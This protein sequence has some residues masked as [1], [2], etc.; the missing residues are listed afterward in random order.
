MKN[1]K[2]LFMLFLGVLSLSVN[3]QY[4]YNVVIG[5]PKIVLLDLEV[6]NDTSITLGLTASTE[7]G[8][9]VDFNSINNRD[10]VVITYK[11]S[12]N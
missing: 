1:Q 9:A 12:D 5:I 6:A 3:A 2:K 7:A 4:A 11:L 10:T 8:N